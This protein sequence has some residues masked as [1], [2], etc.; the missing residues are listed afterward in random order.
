MS[1]ADPCAIFPPGQR[2]AGLIEVLIAA[3]ILAIGI[4]GIIGLLGTSATAQYESI[5][6]IRAVS[7][8]DNILERI[9]R[10]PAGLTTY[11]DRDTTRPLG[12]GSI[13]QEPSPNCLSASCSPGEL[14][15]Y[16]LWS[17][18][19]LLD[20]GSATITEGGKTT[21][22]AS[23]RELRACIDFTPDTG[24]TSTGIVDVILQWRGVKETGDGVQ[25]GNA[26]C[27]GATAGSDKLR[28]QLVLSSYVIDETE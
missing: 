2:G 1:A 18:E 21:N 13:Q 5:Q 17:W 27:G 20:G 10:N 6:R 9:R 23:L 22:T 7:L 16:D 4:L 19:Q 11:D 14:A 8:A 25:A 3:L 28:R 24:K 12:S 26:V 15:A